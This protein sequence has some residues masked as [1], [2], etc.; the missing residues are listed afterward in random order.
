M[1]LDLYDKPF[2][3]FVDAVV[4]VADSQVVVVVAVV[5]EAVVVV[6]ADV[7]V[8]VV[9]VVVTVVVAGVVSYS[10]VAVYEFLLLLKFVIWSSHT[11]PF[12]LQ[13]I[14]SHPSVS[15]VKI[16]LM[17]RFIECLYLYLAYLNAFF[18]CFNSF[19]L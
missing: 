3:V 16:D 11:L 14:L 6:V 17:S 15:L 19:N 5:V 7:V 2:L 8:V 12:L 1:K 4:V 18:H 9:V 13:L 10:Q